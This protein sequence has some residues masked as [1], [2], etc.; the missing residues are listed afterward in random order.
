MNKLYI[1]II[2]FFGH[3]IIGD[4]SEVHRLKLVELFWKPQG[5]LIS[6]ES[7][8]LIINTGEEDLVCPPGTLIPWESL[9][10]GWTLR[11]T[12]GT[13]FASG[14]IEEVL[15]FD[16]WISYAQNIASSEKMAG[17][18]YLLYK[19]AFQSPV[20]WN[21]LS[22]LLDSIKNSEN[23][24]LYEDRWDRYCIM[25]IADELLMNPHSKEALNWL[26]NHFQ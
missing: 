24:A 17:I 16:S 8:E 13:V 20:A 1:N 10:N 26:K 12:G 4:F 22:Q 25:S 15:T 21:H 14:R 23:A 5:L 18:D 3:D 2:S 9:L 7:S 19:R 11:F 6:Q